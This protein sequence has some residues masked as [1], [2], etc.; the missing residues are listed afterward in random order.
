MEHIMAGRD[1]V[2]WAKNQELD[3]FVVFSKDDAHSEWKYK[4]TKC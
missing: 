1:V 2:N 3:F 4:V